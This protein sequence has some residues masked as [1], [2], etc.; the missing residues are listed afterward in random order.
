M[1]IQI[2]R[3]SPEQAAQEVAQDTRES[4]DVQH[5]LPGRSPHGEYTLSVLPDR[6]GVVQIFENS[7]WVGSN[8]RPRWGLKVYIPGPYTNV[9]AS[10]YYI[11]IDL[12]EVS[13]R[14]TPRN[15]HGENATDR[16]SLAAALAAAEKRIKVDADHGGLESWVNWPRDL[17]RVL[18]T[19]AK[20]RGRLDEVAKNLGVFPGKLFRAVA[21]T[22]LSQVLPK[23]TW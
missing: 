10:R 3:I 9:L 21:T 12:Q 17:A 14:R 22:A 20:E 18:Q 16:F 1:L 7:W 4:Y 15:N 2:T 19:L 8:H 13:L 23:V 11:R 6:N 5:S